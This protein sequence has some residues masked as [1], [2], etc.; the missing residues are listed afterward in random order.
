MKKANTLRELGLYLFGV[1]VLKL[2]LIG[3]FLLVLSLSVFSLNLGL[4]I[5]KDFPEL[6]KLFYR[7]LPELAFE[8]LTKNTEDCSVVRKNCGVK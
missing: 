1:M 3:L 7:S 6:N 2:L 5:Q 4:T 8:Q